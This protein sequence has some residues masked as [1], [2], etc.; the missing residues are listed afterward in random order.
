VPQRPSADHATQLNA[1]SVGRS[2]VSLES[3]GNIGELL[4][5][6]VVVITLFYLAFQIRQNTQS[7]RSESYARALER[8]AEMQARFASDS[9]LSD[10]LLKGVRDAQVLTEVD[11]AR[12]SWAFYEMF[13]AFEFM[14]HQAEKGVLEDD[15][16]R[17]WSAT[18]LFWISLPGVRS[19]WRLKPAP[20][21]ASFS[22]HVDSLISASLS[23]PAANQRIDEFVLGEVE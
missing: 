22:S 18:M 7:L 20:F 13:G 11:R 3:L 6:I 17:R 5:G 4:S 10:L 19:W 1:R 12:F 15:V 14:F 16:W 23:D 8:V 21:T 9:D 2:A